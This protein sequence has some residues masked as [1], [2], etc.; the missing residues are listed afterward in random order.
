MKHSQVSADDVRHAFFAGQKYSHEKSV[1]LKSDENF[2]RVGVR[3]GRFIREW[4]Y[5]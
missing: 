4:V 1:A 3:G 2:A 5:V